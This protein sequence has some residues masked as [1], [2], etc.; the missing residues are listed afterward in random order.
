MRPRILLPVML[1]L[2]AAPFASTAA[3]AVKAPADES[4]QLKLN[5]FTRLR[6]TLNLTSPGSNSFSLAQL[7]FGIK[8][9]ISKHFSYTFSLE[10]TN[11]DGENRKLIYDAYIDS[12]IL[13]WVKIRFGQL[14]YPFGLEQTTA[15]PD[16]ELINKADVVTN[17][18]RPTRDIGLQVSRE[19][20][21]R[22]LQPMIALA[23]INGSGSNLNDENT[24]KALVGRLLL[25]PLKGLAVGASLYDGTTGALNS[26]KSRVGAELKYTRGGFLLK[27]EIIA[28]KDAGVKKNGFYATAGYTLAGDNQALVRYERWDADRSVADLDTSRITLAFNRFFGKNVVWQTN[29]E[30]RTETPG[31]KNDVLATQ[32]QIRF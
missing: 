16:L 6:Y 21:I 18:V 3:D 29:Y 2:L 22:H 11:T 12:T 23:I 15:D 19:F 5:G 24:R 25:K 10:G 20:E 4:P 1:A 17:L 26:K 28:G 27:G 9:T 8:G 13:P 14:K 30:H 32:V 31:I 7:R